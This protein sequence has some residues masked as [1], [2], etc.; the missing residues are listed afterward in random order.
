MEIGPC[1]QPEEKW[2][3]NSTSS[4]CESFMFS[5]CRGNR[6]RFATQTSCQDE[7]AQEAEAPSG[8][9]DSTGKV[10]YIIDRRL[11]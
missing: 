4:S 2:F 11:T 6:N 5:G 1:D 3:Y 7:C 10:D 9:Y 8:S